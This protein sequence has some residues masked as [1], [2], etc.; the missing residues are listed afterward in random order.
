M[1]IKL[2]ISLRSNQAMAGHGKNGTYR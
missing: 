1:D 2:M